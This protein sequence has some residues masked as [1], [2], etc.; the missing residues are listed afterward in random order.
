MPARE[1]FNFFA[2]ILIQVSALAEYIALDKPEPASNVVRRVFGHVELL[3]AQL[4][5]GPI[6]P[7][8]RPHSRYRQI[9]EPPCRIVYRHDKKPGKL[10]ILGVMRGE[11][12]FQ[13]RLIPRRD[14]STAK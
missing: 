4:E 8:L 7:E 5:L 3:G 9:V 1:S 14:R 10:Y 6:V 11:K 12:L 2:W 13:K